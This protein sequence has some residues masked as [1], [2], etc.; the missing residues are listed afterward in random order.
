M[1]FYQYII[2]NNSDN[3]FWFMQTF[4]IELLPKDRICSSKVL[5]DI[6]GPELQTNYIK[7]CIFRECFTEYFKYTLLKYEPVYEIPIR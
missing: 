2:N 6:L 5:R 1:S 4:D 7:D 3:I